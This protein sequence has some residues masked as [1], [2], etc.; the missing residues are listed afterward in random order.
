M[1]K[2]KSEIR[3]ISK[4]LNAP[5]PIYREYPLNYFVGRCIKK[6]FK[7]TDGMGESMWVFITKAR[8]GKL[9]GT[10][11]NDPIVATHLRL[12]DT[13]AVGPE[14]IIS[15]KH[16]KEEW[17]QEV[18]VRLA[19]SDFF[20]PVGGPACGDNFGKLYEMGLGPAQALAAWRDYGHR[21]VS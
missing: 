19:K 5:D 3:L 16:E 4:T 8:R 17:L 7:D 1:R 15:V 20:N 11:E 14:E 21:F 13:V 10:L 18:R 2:K 12:G 9:V 6:S